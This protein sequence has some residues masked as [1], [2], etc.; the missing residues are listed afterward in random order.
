MG[1]TAFSLPDVVDVV[2]AEDND[3]LIRCQDLSSDN[4]ISYY[5]YSPVTGVSSSFSYN[6]AA[7]GTGRAQGSSSD[8][9]AADTQTYFSANSV[10]L[11]D[12]NCVMLLLYTAQCNPEIL[13]WSLDKER[14]TPKLKSRHTMTAI[15][16]YKP[17]AMTAHMYPHIL[18]QALMTV[19]IKPGRQRKRPG[20]IPT[21]IHMEMR[22]L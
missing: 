20:R 2:L 4:S 5:K 11:P 22:S 6:P 17:Y 12:A 9:A 10:Y 8:S 16:C 18:P 3:M 14:M 13:I 7:R 19:P 21:T 15:L 1:K